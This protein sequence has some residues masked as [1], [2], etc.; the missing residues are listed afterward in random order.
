MQSLLGQ[1]ELLLPMSAFGDVEE[2]DHGADH[3]PVPANRVRPVLGWEAGPVRAPEDFVVDMRVL[4]GSKR[5]EDF[6]LLHWI[7]RPVFPRMMHQ[8][9]HIP[10]EELARIR[11]A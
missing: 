2:G 3:T 4:V 5:P 10:A 1:A 6:A 9:V 8:V 11:V 7:R